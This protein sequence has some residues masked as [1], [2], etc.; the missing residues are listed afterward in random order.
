MA[1][2]F[3]L[4]L[5]FS[6]F[7]FSAALPLFAQVTTPTGLTPGSSSG[8]GPTLTSSPVSLSWGAVTG[9]ASYE[10]VVERND[11]WGWTQAGTTTALTAGWSY[12]PAF[13]GQD[14]R[15]RVRAYDGSGYSA[16]SADSFF[17]LDAPA[18]GGGSG[19]STPTG[20]TPG[21]VSTP[22]TIS[23]SPLTLAFDA[24]SGAAIYEIVTEYDSSGSYVTD[25][26]FQTAQT[27]WAYNTNSPFSTNRWKVRAGSASGWSAFSV[28]KYW[29]LGSTTG[30]ANMTVTPGGDLNSTGNPGGPFSPASQSY[31][32]SN[33]GTASSNFYTSAAP[34]WYRITPETGT[35]AGG[36]SRSVTVTISSDAN[37]LPA[38]TYSAVVT[39][40]MYWT[41]T[42][43]TRTI[44]L[45]V[46]GSGL[47]VTPGSGLS[48]SGAAGG[49]FSP[50]SQAY[51]LSNTSGSSF[52][53]TATVNQTWVTLSSASGSIAASGT[54]S[55]TASINSGANSLTAGI[56]SATI[57]F[58]NTSTGAGST[59]RTVSL[60]VNASGTAGPMTVSPGGGLSSTGPV[61]GP[62]TPTSID[63]VVTNTGTAPMTWS[64]SCSMAFITL[65]ST[66]GT[67]AAGANTTV[68]A[69]LNSTANGYPAATWSG[70][71]IF[72]NTTNASG[73][74]T[75]PVTL[76]VGSGGGG[77]SAA[78]S[79][80]PNSDLAS[81]GPVGGPFTPGS[82]NYTIANIGTADMTFTVSADQTWVSIFAPTA[83]LSAG[84]SWGTI[85][86]FDASANSLAAGT[87]TANVAFT[88]TT[89]GV[90]NAT[91][92]VTLTVTGGGGSSAAMTVTPA[93]GI[94][95]SGPVG[96]PFTSSSQNYTITNSG[97]ASL[98]WTASATQGWMTVLP[99]SGTLAP[100][101]SATV[102]VSVNGNAI[103][104]AAGTYNDTVTFTNTTNGVGNTTRS[105]TLTLSGGGGGG[106]VTPPT[107]TI[108]TPAP[109]SASTSTSP[110]TISG[111]ASDSV[112]VTQVTWSNATTGGTG[113]AS[114]TT[115]WSASIPL[116]SGSNLITI[117]AKDAANN[118]GSASITILY[119][120]V[121]GDTTPP[122]V[123]I[124]TP[125]A[126]PT[127]SASSSPVTVAGTASDNV[128]VATVTWFNA[129]TGMSGTAA[130]TT[131][132]N[133]S[134]VLN[135]GS[136]VITISAFDAAGNS[137][138][139]V[140]TID[141]G[142]GSSS[143]GGGGSRGH[144]K[145][146]GGSAGALSGNAFWLL[147][148]VGLA[149]VLAARR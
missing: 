71:V 47:V 94:N 6:L 14:Y 137:S 39:F 38:G 26:T 80:T 89:N 143:G 81:T 146:C 50:A 61:G 122:V 126:A 53:Y 5:A 68:T 70:S 40:G 147:A 104:L 118:G 138:T 17:H 101:A 136:N 111:T 100:G 97:T 107:V 22:S 56:Y 85:V 62:F 145:T 64:A 120:P 133:I 24:V 48:S 11:T 52:N 35:L 54:A 123:T 3:V 103:L 96:G 21:G 110:I 84:T 63:Y 88:N 67:L 69:S 129:A 92:T 130:G 115:S 109:P 78:M 93:T 87:Y 1:N 128:A 142:G 34:S 140:I 19:P 13:F 60:T 59:T 99:T 98:D 49:P 144:K 23:N 29:T 102:I 37:T 41:T 90:G 114:G 55:V 30:A 2:K 134:I 65:S 73:D 105:V 66:G 16:W 139:D 42:T 7:S 15:F 9:A 125:S 135:T 27:S 79:V 121:S 112:G 33:I 18:V 95:A 86:Q 4:S 12:P 113:I 10:V 51:T 43:A 25:Q 132:W 141:L 82:L 57:T 119:T 8:P 91:H 117:T 36:E 108:V 124:T 131:S 83:T 76:A 45:T 44:S 20:L 46:A 148:A 72:N 127:F 106:D 32:V 77:G 28:Y 74:T 149:L 58:T 116:A 31:V 75:R